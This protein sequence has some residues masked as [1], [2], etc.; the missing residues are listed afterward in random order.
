MK[1]FQFSPTRLSVKVS[2]ALAITALVP[3]LSQAQ[4]SMPTLSNPNVS[5]ILD[6]YYQSEDRLM[7]ERAE[8]FG[9]GETELALS[10]NIDDMFYGCL[11]YTSDA[12]DE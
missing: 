8:G 2:A 1:N 6:G 5:V 7:T 4:N 10:A 12:A 3:M 11:L 9:L